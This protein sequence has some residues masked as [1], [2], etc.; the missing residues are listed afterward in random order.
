MKNVSFRQISIKNFLSIGN[1]PVVLPFSPGINIITG[2]NLDKD[3]SKNG[4]GK[5]TI[6]DAIFFA[7]FGDPL[8]D[9][10]R[11]KI[12]NFNN[13]KPCE[14]VLEFDVNQNGTTTT[15]KIL[16]GLRPSKCQLFINGENKTKS[17][18]P[19]T[20]E[21]IC[22]ILTASPTVFRNSVIN[23]INTSTP[24]MSFKKIEKRKF[25]EGIMQLEIFG[26]MSLLANKEYLKAEKEKDILLAKIAEI[27]KSLDIYNAQKKLFSEQK[28]EKLAEYD[29]RINSNVA[30]I[31]SLRKKISPIN[32]AY[33]KNAEQ[34]PGLQRDK[35]SV[36]ESLNK[37][38][39]YIG[40]LQSDI[41]HT[42]QSIE[43][44]N[45]LGSRCITCKREYSDA[46]KNEYKIKKTD[47]KNLIIHKREQ[48]QLNEERK[49]GIQQS[50]RSI[51]NRINILQLQQTEENKLVEYNKGINIRIEQIEKLNKQIEKD[52][53]NLR[54]QQSNFDEP[55]K[56]ATEQLTNNTTEVNNIKNKI[57]D[58]EVSK[59]V[60]SEEGIKSSI[61]KKALKILN[62]KINYY[63]RELDSNCVCS[64]NEYFDDTLV[65]LKGTEYSYYNFSGGESKRIDV[66]LLFTFM[67]LRK[68]LTNVCYNIC[69]FDELFDSN[70]DGKGIDQTL[71]ILHNRVVKNNECVYIITHRKDAIK[72][73]QISKII[74]LQKKNGFT[75]LKETENG[76]II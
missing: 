31:E 66:A 53:E 6:S 4:V 18:M 11:D 54:K 35:Q 15:Y 55:I 30:E 2:E 74:E 72:T 8:R 65:D 32:D 75:I 43:E 17:S 27:Q 68:A 50:I 24:F 73:D 34:I 69:I 1:T 71:D 76:T 67:D 37:T 7:I 36:Q 29:M 10:T 16:R 22:K 63:L 20:T 23:T 25:V 42:E 28:E 58:I 48:I 56:N 19:R 21:Q 49:R 59:F 70:L 45:N 38:I 9:I 62:S 13:N 26:D 46:D 52:K 47:L 60:V 51:D 61:I 40:N 12:P 3:D 33:I 5:T 41:A 64:F 14:V 44:I 39:E 57:A